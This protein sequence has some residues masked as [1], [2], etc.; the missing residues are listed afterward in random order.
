MAFGRR[1][2]AA[3]LV[4][5]AFIVCC[6][7]LSLRPAKAEDDDTHLMLFSGRDLWR[8]GAFLHGG[9]ILS[10]GGFEQSGFL[11][12]LL[13]SGGLYRYRAVDLG[14]ETIIGV[15]WLSHLAPGWMIKRGP[16][17]GKF[18]FGP[19]FQS[20]QLYPDD[21]TNRLRGRSVGLRMS[22]DLWDEPTPDMMLAADAALSSVGSNYSARA[23]VGS[24][25]LEH[26]I[27]ARRRR[28]TA[29]TATGNSAPACT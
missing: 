20:H 29:A 5:A 28:C 19:E 21:P 17:E 3:M 10:P 27:S 12:K 6:V 1:V 9:L 15:E 13:A 26:F 23:A 4:A 22:V 7:V 11:L 25:F 18:F 16:F 24:R 2:R 8:N 14:G